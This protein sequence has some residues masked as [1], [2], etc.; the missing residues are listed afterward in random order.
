MGVDPRGALVMMMD[1]RVGSGNGSQVNSDTVV[2][3]SDL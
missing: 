1:P 2:D 3:P